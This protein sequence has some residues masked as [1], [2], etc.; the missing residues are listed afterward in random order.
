MTDS[1]TNRTGDENAMRTE[2]AIAESKARYGGF[3]ENLSAKKHAL[4]QGVKPVADISQLY[5][6]GDPADWDG[7][8][9]FLAQ[10][11][12]ANPLHKGS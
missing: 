11:R 10:E 1:L 7:F 2:S 12:A 8:D 6:G 4:R 9:E 5:G 3:Y